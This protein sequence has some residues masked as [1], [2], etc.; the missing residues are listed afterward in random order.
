[1]YYNKNTTDGSASIRVKRNTCRGKTYNL[2]KYIQQQG[3]II[4]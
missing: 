3:Y 2:N 1:M 4:L